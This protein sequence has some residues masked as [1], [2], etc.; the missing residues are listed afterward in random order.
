M[1][2][3]TPTG[4][5]PLTKDQLDA[6][7]DRPQ[8]GRPQILAGLQRVDQVEAKLNEVIDHG[9][10]MLSADFD[11]AQGIGAH[12]RVK[13]GGRPQGIVGALLTTLL[14]APSLPNLPDQYEVQGNATLLPLTGGT[15]G[16]F[17][18]PSAGF[19]LCMIDFAMVR[20]STAASGQ[21]GL[22]RN[23]NW[24]D[25]YS[26]SQVLGNDAFNAYI[27]GGSSTVR[28]QRWCLVFAAAND[29]LCFAAQGADSTVV[30]GFS[31]VKIR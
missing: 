29:R 8:I 19:Y 23:D 12:M 30:F 24:A 6:G 13:T 17:T 18:C 16:K 20:D 5:A 27:Q 10:P 9:E 1:A 31:C 3:P 15:A 2:W 28:T 14:A 25:P 11:A 4:N 21:I 22:M 26:Q 7:N